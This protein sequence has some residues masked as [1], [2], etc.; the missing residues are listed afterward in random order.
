[1]APDNAH[2]ETFNGNLRDECLNLQRFETIAEAKR[3]IEAWLS[4]YKESRPHI[5]LG[6]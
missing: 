4:N 3:I 6:D 2:N 5:E 1:M